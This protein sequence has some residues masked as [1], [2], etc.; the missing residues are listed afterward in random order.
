ML[1]GV[2]IIGL[3]K[4]KQ[5]SF[6]YRII[7]DIMYAKLLLCIRVLEVG[8]AEVVKSEIKINISYE[9]LA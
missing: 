4:T 6:S 7:Y 2:P 3:A 1:F 5:N 9:N 8:Y